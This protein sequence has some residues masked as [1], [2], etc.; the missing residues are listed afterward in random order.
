LLVESANSL[1]GDGAVGVVDKGKAARS[2][3]FPVG[4]QHDLGG[5]ADA[6]QV[7]PQICLACRVWQIANKQTN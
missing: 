1:L 6:R 4:W 5:Y 7:L 3:G 2:A